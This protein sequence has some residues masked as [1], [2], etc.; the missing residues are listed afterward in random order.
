[1]KFN[2]VGG[3]VAALLLTS[4]PSALAQD[5][6]E[7]RR[8]RIALGAQ[9][10]PSYPGSDNVSFRPLVDISRARGTEQFE[11]EAPDESFGFPVLRLERLTVGPVLN[12]QGGRSADDVGVDLPKAGF[13]VEPGVFVQYNLSERVRLRSELRKGLGGHEGWIG[14]VGADFVARRADD[15][16]LSAGPRVTFADET[17]NRSYFSVAAGSPSGL[18]PFTAGG[19]LQSVGATLGYVRQ[20][21]HR[22]GM[23]SYAKYDRLVGDAADSPITRVVGSRDQI[24]GG[25]GLTYTFG[26]AGS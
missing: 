9:V 21:T 14:N 15:W 13:T 1:M 12:F 19:G 2:F 7:P 20:I 11:F 10:V 18:P 24:S 16:L 3:A 5:G 17:Y 8:T 22:W 25:L 23:Y 4:A 6:E 26:A